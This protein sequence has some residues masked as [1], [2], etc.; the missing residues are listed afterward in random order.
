MVFLFML[1]GSIDWA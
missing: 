1:F